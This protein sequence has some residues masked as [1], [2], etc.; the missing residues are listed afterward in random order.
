MSKETIDLCEFMSE[1]HRT[2]V[3][4]NDTFIS[5]TFHQVMEGFKYPEDFKYEYI[6]AVEQRGDGSGYETFYVFKRLSDGKHFYYYIYD[7]R[8]EQYELDE[9]EQEVT[10]QWDFECQY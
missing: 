4:M 5:D 1:M 2:A 9:C 6:D 7:C 10:V 3:E 8:I